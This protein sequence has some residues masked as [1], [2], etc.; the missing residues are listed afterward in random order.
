MTYT[1]LVQIEAWKEIQDAY[2]WYEEKKEGLGDMLIEEIE[3]CYN[4]LIENPERF[5]YINHLYRRIRTDRFPYILMYEIEGDKII[6][7]RV[8]HIKQQPL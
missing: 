3:V 4:S 7:S 1:V 8:R 2:D 6:I 5:P